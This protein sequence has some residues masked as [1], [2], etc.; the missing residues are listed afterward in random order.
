MF[1]YNTNNLLLLFIIIISRLLLYVNISGHAVY[2]FYQNNFCS[3][4]SVKK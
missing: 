1:Q 4:Y 3:G 2:N